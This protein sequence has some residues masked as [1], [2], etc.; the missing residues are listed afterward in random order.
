M[1]PAVFCATAAIPLLRVDIIVLIAY[2]A[3]PIADCLIASLFLPKLVIK[4]CPNERPTYVCPISA[5]E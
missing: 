2:D 3:A 1:F 5:L 4:S